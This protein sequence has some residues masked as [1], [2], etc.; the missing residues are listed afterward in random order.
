VNEVR[1]EAAEKSSAAIGAT[2]HAAEQLLLA[3]DQRHPKPLIDFSIYRPTCRRTETA[4]TFHDVIDIPGAI[5]SLRHG[6]P[7]SRASVTT[8]SITR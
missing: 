2:A 5:R 4:G 8:R 7:V 6:G 1:G 3:A